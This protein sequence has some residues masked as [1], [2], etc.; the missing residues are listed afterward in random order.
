MAKMVYIN[1]K[2]RLAN[3]IILLICM[4]NASDKIV[5]VSAMH[6]ARVEWIEYPGSLQ[7]VIADQTLITE[8]RDL[9]TALDRV[10]GKQVNPLIFS[11]ANTGSDPIVSIEIHIPYEGSK[12]KPVYFYLYET[13]VTDKD[14]KPV[15]G[16]W[17][18][19]IESDP[20]N[21]VRVF[22]FLSNEGVQ[23]G[24]FLYFW[25]FF[26]GGPES[27]TYIF[28]VT[29]CD[30]GRFTGKVE[31]YTHHLKLVLSSFPT[32]YQ[33]II[34]VTDGGTTD[35]SPGTYTR[36]MGEIVKV[37]AL[38][39]P[40]YKFVYW[41]INGSKI[42][43][44]NPLNILMNASYILKA[45]FELETYTLEII[46]KT[47]GT[48]S[49]PPGIHNYQYGSSV[50]VTAV[51]LTNYRFD[52]WILDGLPTGSNNTITVLMNQNHVLE[53]I[54]VIINCTL[55]IESTVGGTTDPSPGTY[56]Y[57]KDSNVT[58][59]ARPDSGY[60]FDHWILDGVDVGSDNP[61]TITMD[62]NHTLKA[63]FQ[64]TYNL[65]ISTTVGGSTNPVP[66]TY[67]YPNG[68]NVSV[69]AIP[70]ADYI[71][72]HWEFDG[73]I[74]SSAHTY[75]VFMNMSHTL[76]AVFSPVPPLN[77][78]ISPLSASIV[79][80]Q[81]IT[82][83][84]TVSGG[85]SP[86]TYQWYLNGTPFSSATTDSWTFRP[87]SKGTFYVYLTI[88]DS[89]NRSANSP[90]AK[91]TVK[92]EPSPSNSLILILIGTSIGLIAALT[93]FISRKK[94]KVESPPLPEEFSV[95][96]SVKPF[97]EEVY[98]QGETKPS[99]ITKKDYLK[100]VDDAVFDYIVSHG[101][102]I[103]LSRAAAELGISMEELKASIERL[104]EKGLIE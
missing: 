42:V 75:Q 46:V 63:V 82:F 10:S 59:S 8:W 16:W 72:E 50:N 19:I 33:L 98:G 93:G 41:E 43:S 77:V 73:R 86:Y 31:T 47:G 44:I 84:S 83:T 55:K 91:I 85:K 62:S 3:V 78:S 79:V 48:T 29:T 36:S 14:S 21:K 24:N 23:P 81:L 52:Y 28:N 18:Q 104:K 66:G 51:P 65:T 56:T 58:V 57:N 92:A 27:G 13:R 88:V 87:N 9:Y 6:L 7:T 97:S 4:L 11:V 26:N 74:V 22:R 34:Y 100:N 45:C 25:M 95:H 101:G 30:D 67:Q 1:V 5:T 99:S 53:A 40:N 17:T 54:F 39:K 76:K 61:Y 96:K 20:F 32:S 70:E 2:H 60:K 12:F 69:T 15:P 71:F 102:T 103:S 38:A 68:T 64:I 94:K 35:P 80:G 37:T 90:T 49:P 89:R